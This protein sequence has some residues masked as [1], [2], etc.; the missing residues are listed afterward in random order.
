MSLLSSLN[1]FI[2]RPRR[3]A[4]LAVLF[5]VL[6]VVSASGLIPLSENRR[7]FPG[8]E[9]LLAGLCWVCAMAL[10]YC[11]CTGLKPRAGR[12]SKKL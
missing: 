8:H 9:W 1:V 2:E 7:Y 11:A 4:V 12:E 3:T 6:G 5:V 10:A